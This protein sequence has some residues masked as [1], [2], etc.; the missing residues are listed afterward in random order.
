MGRHILTNPKRV[1]YGIKEITSGRM[2]ISTAAVVMVEQR[3]ASV[4]INRTFA[5]PKSWLTASKWSTPEHMSYVFC[6]IY[7]W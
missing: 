2:S 7:L 1:E 4:H 3:S 5:A 6:G